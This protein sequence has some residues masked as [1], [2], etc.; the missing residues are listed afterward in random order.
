MDFLF[1]VGCRLD[2]VCCEALLVL[3][4]VGP[5][6]VYKVILPLYKRQLVG[7][8]LFARTCCYL[9]NLLGEVYDV[10]KSP[11]N[12]R[13]KPRVPWQGGVCARVLH[14]WRL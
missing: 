10:S 2:H 8:L 7:P 14:A 9:I 13:A 5:L 12:A 11:A 4:I 1:S 6:W 3:C